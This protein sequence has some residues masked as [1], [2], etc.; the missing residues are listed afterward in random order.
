MD[1]DLKRKLGIT[2]SM[3]RILEDMK[4]DDRIKKALAPVPNFS[5]APVSS[6]EFKMPDIHV[7]TPR[8]R[9]AYQSAS[10]LMEAIA[11]EAQQWK[12]RLPEKYQPAVL[13]ILYGGIEINV[14]NLPQVSFHGIRIEGSLREA[15]CSLFAHQSTVQLL[16]YAQEKNPEVHRNP[17]G[18]FGV[19]TGWKYEL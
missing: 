8:E 1:N 9:N 4:K 15:P 13:A 17:I 19:K 3:E 2:P 10:V 5:F 7:P 12:D 6:P 16:C 18:L 11:D 14:Q